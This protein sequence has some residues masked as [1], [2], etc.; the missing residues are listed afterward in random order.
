MCIVIPAWFFIA[1]NSG[2]EEYFV[3]GKRKFR[4]LFSFTFV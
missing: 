1:F 4:A 3:E 2:Q